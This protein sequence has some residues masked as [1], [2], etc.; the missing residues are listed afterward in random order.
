MEPSRRTRAFLRDR[1]RNAHREPSVTELCVGLAAFVMMA[2][3][4]LYVVA[5]LGH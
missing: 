2:A 4:C 3:T 1:H 5:A